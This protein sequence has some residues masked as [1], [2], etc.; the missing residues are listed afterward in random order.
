M[1]FVP[2]VLIWRAELVPPA[3]APW[4]CAAI[5]ISALY[6]F[7][8][9]DLK[10]EDN[11]FRGCPALWNVVA[12]YLFVTQ[13]APA[14]AVALAALAALTFTSVPVV[15]PFRVRDYGAWLPLLS[16]VWAAA[17]LALL[18]PGWSAGIRAALFWTSVVLVV[19]LLGLGAL[20]G[21]RGPRTAPAGA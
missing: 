19:I 3:L 8:R 5:L 14:A 17:T 2:A 6:N 15:H 16:L 12:L 20:R 1:P 18:W 4:L 10:T 7:T 13:P 11:Y 21:L 9:R